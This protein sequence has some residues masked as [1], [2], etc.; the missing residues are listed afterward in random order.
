MPELFREVGDVKTIDN[1]H[2]VEMGDHAYLP[3]GVLVSNSRVSA[4]YEYTL[5]TDYYKFVNQVRGFNFAKQAINPV[6]DKDV[7]LVFVVPS[8]SEEDL[9]ELQSAV[10]REINNGSG[11]N[12]NIRVEPLPITYGEFMGFAAHTLKGYKPN[13]ETQSL[14]ARVKKR[15]ELLSG[16]SLSDQ[17]R[18]IELARQI[19]RMFT[20]GDSEAVLYV[21]AHGPKH[22]RPLSAK[23]TGV[24]TTPRMSPK[25]LG[26]PELFRLEK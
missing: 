20:T 13:G 23:N 16:I 5:S 25:T 1:G 26:E 3:D 11:S 24:I 2:G 7:E 9:A 19:D 8:A 12:P 22:V 17:E 14:M 21:A 4:M 10:L 15:E 6:C 18:R